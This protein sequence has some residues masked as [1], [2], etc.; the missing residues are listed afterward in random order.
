MPLTKICKP[1]ELILSDV[2]GVLTDGR[3][4]F[5]DQGVEIKNFH[6]RDGMGIK[7]WQ[8]A[9]YPFGIVTAR[10]TP[11]VRNRA[12]ELDIDLL[13]QGSKNKRE[14]VKQICVELD[15]EP[16]QV[17]FIGDDLPDVAAMKYVGLAIAPADA[18]DEAKAVAQHVTEKPG[19]Q[20]AVRE[21]ITMILKK[22]GRWDEVIETITN[23]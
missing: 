2:D 22:K 23:P 4:T 13:R 14:T 17:C 6:A 10:D 19:G 20:G 7:L 21:A 9:G 11:I 8:K 15:L 1:I 18:S 12:V 16:E 5:T 3:L